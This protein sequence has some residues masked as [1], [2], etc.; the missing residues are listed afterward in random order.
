VIENPGGPNNGNDPY[1]PIDDYY[2]LFALLLCGCVIF[3]YRN[4]ASK[5]VRVKA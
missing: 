5:L 4:K 2:G 1:V 3:W